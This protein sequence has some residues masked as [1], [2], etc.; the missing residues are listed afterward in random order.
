M[1]KVT[2]TKEYEIR[3]A[4]RDAIILDPLISLRKLQD[5]L[6]EKGYKTAQGN[7]LHIDYVAKL[8][9]KVN[10]ENLWRVVNADKN[11][12]IAE[13]QERYRLV[14]DRLLRIA[15][16]T[17]DLQKDG[18]PAPSYKDQI[19]ALNAI[20]KLDAAVLSAE[21]DMGIFERHIGTLEVEKRYR[22]LPPEV[23]TAM[24]K[25]FQNL[26]V[27]PEPPKQIEGNAT[28]DGKQP[29]D[30]TAVVREG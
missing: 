12:R 28:A 5:A 26:G 16:Y 18:Y 29:S 10:S 20:V 11:K 9:K 8:V 30:T 14:L 15:F 25:A 3:R 22:P 23:K 27:L 13:I 7:S 6:F 19:A 21:M 4:I 1:P 2:E 24:L 17:E